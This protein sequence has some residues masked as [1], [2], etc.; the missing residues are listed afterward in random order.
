MVLA[1]VAG[2]TALE[3]T[4]RD[5]G[6]SHRKHRLTWHQ[7]RLTRLERTAAR[8][9]DPGHVYLLRLGAIGVE[10]GDRLRHAKAVTRAQCRDDLRG[11]RGIGRV[12]LK[13]TGE[14]EASEPT[15]KVH[16]SVLS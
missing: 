4:H 8:R 3:R 11:H 10:A 9:E 12:G 1:A 2:E 5:P 14:R 15:F 16:P 6:T 7:L 13:R